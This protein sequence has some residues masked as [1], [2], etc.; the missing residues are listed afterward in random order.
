MSQSLRSYC[1]WVRVVGCPASGTRRDH[2]T[3]HC[4][5]SGSQLKLPPRPIARVKRKA[6]IRL[7]RERWE[8]WN[9]FGLERRWTKETV[10]AGILKDQSSPD[11]LWCM[12]PEFEGY[13][14]TFR[15][16]PRSPDDIA[17]L[18]R[19]THPMSCDDRVRPEDDCVTGRF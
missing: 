4:G 18:T 5:Q 15:S 10:T 1:A 17:D 14:P 19:G 16:N 11:Q 2:T 6:R 8:R 12:V 9:Q 3:P 7:R 13:Q